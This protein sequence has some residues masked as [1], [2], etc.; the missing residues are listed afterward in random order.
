MSVKGK[1]ISFKSRS[2]GAVDITIRNSQEFTKFLESWRFQRQ[3]MSSLLSEVFDPAFISSARSYSSHSIQSLLYSTLLY[4]T[5]L[6]IFQI[7]SSNLSKPMVR[8]GINWSLCGSNSLGTSH[9]TQG[10]DDF[11]SSST[12]GLHCIYCILVYIGVMYVRTSR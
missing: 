9:S 12:A 6:D 8:G 11:S 3:H 5:L 4:S 7:F 1:P 10:R 2:K